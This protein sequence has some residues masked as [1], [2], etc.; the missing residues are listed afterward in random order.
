M[1][2]NRNL[3]VVILNYNDPD[4]TIRYIKE[5]QNNERIRLI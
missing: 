4:N 3:A 5:I 2:A 1:K